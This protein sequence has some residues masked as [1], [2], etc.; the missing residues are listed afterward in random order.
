MGPTASA[1]VMVHYTP[2]K[3]DTA[4]AEQLKTPSVG[5]INRT[6]N[7]KTERDDSVTR[8]RNKSKMRQKA[9]H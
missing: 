5:E 2:G 1:R 7:L 9:N 6:K 4:G 8:V 3:G